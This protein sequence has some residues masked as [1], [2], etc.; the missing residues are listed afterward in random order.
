MKDL[1]C[2]ALGRMSLAFDLIKLPPRGYARAASHKNGLELDKTGRILDQPQVL[3]LFWNTPEVVFADYGSIAYSLWRAQE[4]S[5]FRR[6]EKYLTEPVMDFGCGD[7]SFASVLFKRLAFGVDHDADALAVAR[8][9]GLYDQTVLSTETQ[10]PIADE[11]V[12]SVFSNSTLEHLYE[13]GAIL[14]EFHRIL[15]PQG[16]LVF[17][18]PVPAYNQHLTKYFGRRACAAIDKESFHRNLLEESDWRKRLGSLGF[19]VE[20][21]T[22]YQPPEVTYW[23]RML[24]IF[25]KRGAARLWPGINGRVWKLLQKFLIDMVDRSISQTTAD[26][27]NLLVIAQKGKGN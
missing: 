18:V 1:C 16:F 22:L 26:G 13:L 17:T 15:K 3:P 2:Q 5:I 14:K 20:K 27:A 9:Y 4:L 24:R 11:S 19:T 23:Y 25:G 8:A 21:T 12:G 7:G 10:I 6:H